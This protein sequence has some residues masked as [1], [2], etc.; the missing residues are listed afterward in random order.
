ME[1]SLIIP[2]V[3]ISL[4][5]TDKCTAECL[6]C[7]FGCNRSNKNR[8]TWPEIKGYIEQA[9]DEF[10]T[11]KLLVITGGECF[12]IGQDLDKTIKY[13]SKKGLV[14]RAITNAFWATTFKS[15]YLKLKRLKALGLSELNIS[16]GEEHQ[17]WVKFDN[18]IFALIAAIK[19]DITVVVNIETAPSSQFNEKNIYHDIRLK[20]YNIRSNSNVHILNGKWMYFKMQPNQPEV[21]AD[22]CNKASNSVINSNDRCTSLFRDIVISSQHRMYACCGLTCTHIPYLYIGNTKKYRLSEL[23]RRHFDDFIKIWLFT[24]GPAKILNYVQKKL[25]M[26]PQDTSDWHICRSCIELF[27]NQDYINCLKENYKEELS[28]VILKY[29]LLKQKLTT[30]YSN[31]KCHEKSEETES[32]EDR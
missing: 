32:Q 12:T 7:C 6:N 9:T 14:V 11:I 3:S 4:I 22:K 23:Y 15:A 26:E 21:S 16:T 25:G 10:S 2:P 27:K 30:I 24:E 17:Q 8:L 5:V 13:A 19:L 1:N 31:I 28:N 20:K 18:I 29:S